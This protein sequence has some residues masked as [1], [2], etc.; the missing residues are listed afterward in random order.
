MDLPETP[1]S[2]VA[3]SSLAAGEMGDP[4]DG[5][6]R[7][8][9]GKGKGK[10]KRKKRKR[11]D[12]PSTPARPSDPLPDCR[13]MRLVD[14]LQPISTMLDACTVTKPAPPTDDGGGTK[15]DGGVGKT[16]GFESRAYDGTLTDFMGLALVEHFAARL[17]RTLGAL[18]DDFE[19]HPPDALTAVLTGAPPSDT[20]LNTSRAIAEAGE[21][22]Q[23]SSKE[24]EYVLSGSN[25]AASGELS[26]STAGGPPS[27]S[28]GISSTAGILLS[29]RTAMSHNHYKMSGVLNGFRE[30]KLKGPNAPRGGF[31]QNVLGRVSGNDQGELAGS[32][33]DGE[34]RR[35][36]GGGGGR[37]GGR[38]RATRDSQQTSGPGEHPQS[39]ATKP[40]PTVGVRLSPRL[41]RKHPGADNDESDVVRTIP[42]TAAAS[43]YTPTRK[44][45]PA[46]AAV[47]NGS[48]ITRTRGGVLVGETPRKR[49]GTGADTARSSSRRGGRAG[50]TATDHNVAGAGPSSP[51]A[52][53][54]GPRK[55]PSKKEGKIIP[56]E[57]HIPCSPGL[58][59][60]SPEAAPTKRRRATASGP[61]SPTESLFVAESPGALT[62]SARR[63]GRI[64]SW[65]AAADRDGVSR[66]LMAESAVSPSARRRGGVVPDTPA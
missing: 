41:N 58:L 6:G 35:S 52:S 56:E 62:S 53:G 14:Y 26:S 49:P 15:V 57:A 54:T 42:E 63:S 55:Q 32:G 65:G 43:V 9:K 19:C 30:V 38:S 16:K 12:G 36:N 46:A 2:L 33:Q 11:K 50:S 22:E 48:D 5:K 27:S 28:R 10:G 31:R 29:D 21:V 1:D 20:S 44:R 24:T 61:A 34:W 66:Q 39:P 3:F 17:P 45:R 8:S 37:R 7:K 40:S 4:T 13:R 60:A 64:A 25:A 23:A 47:E 51:V 59:M 18:F